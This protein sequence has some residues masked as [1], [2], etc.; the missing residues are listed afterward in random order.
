M[1]NRILVACAAFLF[2]F[3]PGQGHLL[4][5][6]AAAPQARAEPAGKSQVIR[7]PAL[8]SS[9]RIIRDVDGLAH[10]EAR[11]EHD[12]F[13]L[14]GWVHAQDRLFQMDVN[15]RQPSGTLAELLGPGALPSDVQL[16]TIGLRRSAERSWAAIQADAQAG[17]ETAR[18][19]EAAMFAYAEG[20]NAYV[21]AAGGVLPPEYGALNLGSFEPWVPVDSIV[22][23]KLIAFGLSFDLDDIENTETLAA[24]QSVLGQGPG[25]LL[26]AE[27]L[28]R[29]AP[30]DPASTVP[31]AGSS[32]P[33][34]PPK[35]APGGQAK[36]KGAAGAPKIHP[37]A[38]TL[39]GEYLR[40]ARQVPL[41]RT[42]IEN[43]RADRGS[44]NWGVTGEKSATGYP[45]IANDPHLSLDTPTTFY[46]MH[47]SATGYDAV[48]NGFAGTP[49]IITGQNREIAWGPTTNPMDVTDVFLDTLV[50]DAGAPLGLSI[51]L[52]GGGL[53]QIVPVP[54]S[55]RMNIGGNVVPVPPD[56]NI[57]P[58]TLTVP[59]RYDGVILQ[60]LGGLAPGNAVLTA[61]YTGFGP[62]R[63]LE[64]FY[65]WNKARN[66]DD[67]LEGLTRFDFGSQNWAYADKKGN[68][69]YFTSAEMPIRTDLELLGTAA[70]GIPP[71]FIRL[72][73]L[74]L[75]Q[76][77]PRQNTYPGQ[78]TPYEI[79]GPREM[80]QVVNPSNGFFVN[81][82]N[83][84]AGTTLDNDVL[85]QFRDSGGVF[86]LNP[87]Y[88]S[89]FRAG[90]IT[91]RV[92]RA[93]STGDQK[94]S[95]EEMADIQA[96]VGLLDAEF[97]SPLIIAAY[98][99][100]LAPGADPALE[101]ASADP[102]LADAIDRLEMWAGLDYQAKTGI[103]EG[104]DSEDADGD[105]AGSLDAD[106]VR[107]SVAT[108]VYSV[109]RSSFIRS[110][111]DSTLQG[112][113]LGD[114]L[115]GSS[116]AMTA[117]RNLVENGGNSASGLDFFD[118]GAGDQ[119]TDVQVLM[120]AS[121]SDA[122]DRLAGP[123]FGDAF[124][125]SQD[126]DDYRWGLLHRIVFD[127]PLGGP[128][129]VP[130]AFNFFPAPVDGL[131]GIP[132]D[133]GFGTADA[134]S[135]NARA[136][137]V[138]GFMFG[139]GPTNRWVSEV[140]PPGPVSQSVWPGGTSAIPGDTFYVFP[141]LPRWLTND[142]N[143][144]RF[145][146]GDLRGGTYSEQKFRP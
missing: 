142:A 45:I 94:L 14:Q 66:L 4:A 95:V 80:P 125:G 42:L 115:P 9:A 59:A 134:S 2:V 33:V 71:Y 62:T 60:V 103:P 63:E 112:I 28:Y 52:P 89:G 23:G 31:D 73:G 140:P 130:P 67:F 81:A 126:I 93:L 8:K 20:V 29:S 119:A 36:A 100:G 138:D 15:R 99:A 1:S 124:A 41:L 102:R 37:D 114:Y 65:L 10:V 40:K 113:G 110:T 21:D 46:P 18:G 86:Y 51:A 96:D 85:N 6:P 68:L 32:G 106:E 118:G 122:L 109:W 127:S 105:P 44:N 57:P 74:D 76:W 117:L 30:F 72:G 58:F 16:R 87:G 84:P 141:M 49:F 53:G 128:F 143:P 108:T 25:F 48:G 26:F 54:E 55:Y 78:V 90:S 97:F 47:I 144:I 56:P 137:G 38:A 12:M 139:S 70:G 5:A 116:L 13:F 64:T 82:N 69:G 146:P 91:E 77:L 132:T 17:D 120:L 19:V 22:I 92:R 121:L 43:E 50:A 79:L 101:L 131:R 98:Y 39:S 7:L 133:G 123:E 145:R 27:D 61:Q 83:D 35:K 136:A 135:H 75:H 24:F 88:A 107:A 111:L 129:S 3:I 104:Y 34:Q 11:N